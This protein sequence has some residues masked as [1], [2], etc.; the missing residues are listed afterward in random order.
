MP[1]LNTEVVAKNGACLDRFSFHK[2]WSKPI[3]HYFVAIMWQFVCV[4]VPQSSPLCV[5]ATVQ[6]LPSCELMKL[7]SGHCST[8]VFLFPA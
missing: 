2:F 4:P 3:G 6:H 7:C 5:P 1:E 8:C